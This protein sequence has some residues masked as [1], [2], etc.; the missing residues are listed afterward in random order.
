MAVSATP[1]THRKSPSAVDRLIQ[2]HL[3]ALCV[4]ALAIL[5]G[6]FI[7]QDA[8]RYDQW[9]FLSVTILILLAA[10]ALVFWL[11]RKTTHHPLMTLREMEVKSTEQDAALGEAD[12]QIDEM[13]AVLENLSTVDALTGLK[14]HRAFQEQIVIEQGR[15][16]R[17]GHSLSLLLLDV[18]RFKSYNV[19]YGHPKGDQALKLIGELLKD[20]ART[21]DIPFRYGGEE[22]AVILTETDTM[23]AIVLGERIRHAIASANGLQRPVTASIGIATLTPG[24]SGVGELIAQA[25]RAL[26]HAKGEGRNRVSHISRLPQRVEENWRLTRDGELVAA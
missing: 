20:N 21:S 15:A 14:N 1:K 6:Q 9:E 5:A 23:G 7:L 12:R 19:A 13:R 25:D 16:L 24:L 8:L 10:G 2:C 4:V 17:H 3:L 22:F 11:F 18:D 26:C